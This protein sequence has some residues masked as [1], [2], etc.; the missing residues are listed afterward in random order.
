M[1][2]YDEG[3]YYSKHQQPRTEVS[4]Q[5]EQLFELCQQVENAL[6][7]ETDKEETSSESTEEEIPNNTSLQSDVITANNH[8]QV[9][10]DIM[11]GKNGFGT[12]EPE[13]F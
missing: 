2:L 1:Q 6:F 12:F 7:N 8:F 4:K 13:D 11:H 5:S 3:K 9:T 10:L